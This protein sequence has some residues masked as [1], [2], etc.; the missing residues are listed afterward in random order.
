MISG[1]IR[2]GGQ[3]QRNLDIRR[4]HRLHPH[5]DADITGR[6]GAQ[7]LEAV[8]GIR[9]LEG[10]ILQILMHDGQRRGGLVGVGGVRLDA[11]RLGGSLVGHLGP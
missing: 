4:G 3:E 10:E 1:S 5:V 11:G 2:F 6:H 7:R 9:V 8:R